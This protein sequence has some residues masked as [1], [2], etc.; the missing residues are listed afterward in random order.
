MSPRFTASKNSI[1]LPDIISLRKSRR[2]SAATHRRQDSN[3]VAIFDRRVKRIQATYIL[4]IQENVD[5]LTQLAPLVYNPIT[6]PH[7]P[8][9]KFTECVANSGR[10]RIDAYLSLA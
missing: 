6:Q 2:R 8:V 1:V 5:V 7:M 10:L 9:P 4:T 3:F